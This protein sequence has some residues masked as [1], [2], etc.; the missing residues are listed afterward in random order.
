MAAWQA[1]L[2]VV[3]SAGSGRGSR[4]R[5]GKPQM[6]AIG[7]RGSELVSGAG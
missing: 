2:V 1:G 3:T 5:L 7:Q 4:W 6:W